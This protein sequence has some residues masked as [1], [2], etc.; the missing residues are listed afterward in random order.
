MDKKF[1]T[2]TNLEDI[3]NFVY[4]GNATITLES[5]KTNKHFTFKVKAAKKDDKTSPFFVSVLSG[6][7]NYSNFSYVGVIK[8][9]KKEFK[10]TQK[11]KVSSDAIS[12]KAF[13]YFFNQLLKGKINTDLNVYHSGKCGRCGRKLTTPESLERGLGPECSKRK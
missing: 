8:S 7:D 11:S 13:N 1:K 2:L 9:D 6:T 12:Y 10:L 4:G 5:G 3:K